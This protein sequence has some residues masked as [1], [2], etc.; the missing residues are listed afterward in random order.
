M[1][2]IPVSLIVATLL[3]PAAVSA[4]T[5]G[6]ES[7]SSHRGEDGKRGGQPAFMEAWKAADKDSD[8]SLSETEFSGL[9][10]IQGIPEEKRVNLF[11]RLDKNTD[12]KLDRQE[13]GQMGRGHDGQGPP[14]QRLWELDADRSGGVSFEEFKAGRVHAKFDPEKQQALF[15]RLDSNGDGVITPADRP[16]PP[17]KR[18]GQRPQQKRDG[19]RPQQK[20]GPGGQSDGLR[21]EPRQMI[22]QL[23]QNQDGMLSFG[24]FR[25]GPAVKDLTEDEQEERF[26]ALDKDHDLKISAKDFPSPTQ[27]DGAKRPGTPPADVE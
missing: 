18:D 13:L 26:E 21:M 19:E 17:F 10:R 27:R 1:K 16:K 5:E 3:T 25:I 15:R 7:G 24:E 9:P 8:G 6:G 12:G 20:R 23:D 11:K 2:T 14:M 22:G 4:Q